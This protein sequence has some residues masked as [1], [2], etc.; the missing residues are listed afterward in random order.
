MMSITYINNIFFST[1]IIT[2]NENYNTNEYYIQLVFSNNTSIYIK[3]IKYLT[4]IY[5]DFNIYIKS[6]FINNS[7]CILHNNIVYKYNLPPNI[8]Y[9]HNHIENIKNIISSPYNTN[10]ILLKNNINN[11]PI[12]LFYWIYKT[13]IDSVFNLEHFF[14]KLNKICKNYLHYKIVKSYLYNL[15]NN[16]FNNNILEIIYKH[17]LL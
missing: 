12:T 17:I 6:L 2:S 14:F 5:L 3:Y 8:F 16:I 15:N 13:N 4:K 10:H 11:K 9:I 1:E 7:N